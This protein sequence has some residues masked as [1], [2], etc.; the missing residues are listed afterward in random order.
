MV[1]GVNEVHVEEGERMFEK[2][3]YTE[4]W[5][6]NALITQ[7]KNVNELLENLRVESKTYGELLKKL[8]RLKKNVLYNTNTQSLVSLIDMAIKQIEEEKDALY[9]KR[10]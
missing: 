9:I 10:A 1:T 5:I 8:T 2:D 7:Q 3:K 4:K 6:A